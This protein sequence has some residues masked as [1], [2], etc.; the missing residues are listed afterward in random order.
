MRVESTNNDPIAWSLGIELV[1]EQDGQV[2]DS[3]LAERNLGRDDGC[4]VHNSERK[5][6]LNVNLRKSVTPSPKP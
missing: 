2:A 4:R 1:L 6:A 5:V 3:N